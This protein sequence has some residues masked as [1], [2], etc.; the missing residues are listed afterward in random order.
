MTRLYLVLLRGDLYLSSN[1]PS[2]F[3]HRA[4]ATYM[5]NPFVAIMQRGPEY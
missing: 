2:E 4:I 3:V 1:F 5:S